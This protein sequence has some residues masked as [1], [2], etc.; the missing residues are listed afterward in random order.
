MEAGSGQRKRYYG[1]LSRWMP[2]VSGRPAFVGRVLTRAAASLTIRR[3]TGEMHS[4]NTTDRLDALLDRHH[5]PIERLIARYRLPLHVFFLEEM[6]E[7]ARGFQD[8][9]RSVYPESVVAFAVKSNPCRGAV[10]AAQRLGLGADVASEY[11]L[12]AALEEGIDPSAIICNGNAKSAEYLGMALH[13]GATIAL[14]ND[15]EILRLEQR[16]RRENAWARVLVRFRGMP[17]SGLTAVDQTTAADWTKFGFHLDEAERLFSRIRSSDRLRFCGP[18]AHIGT[19]IADPVGYQLLLDHLLRLAGLAVELGLSVECIDVGGGFPVTFLTDEE[20]K[21]LT[22]RLLAR[23]RGDSPISEA[24]TWND[25]PMGYGHL[26]ARDKSAPRWIGKSYWSA[27]PASR[28][29]AHI[30]DHRF[31]DGATVIDRLAALGRPRLIV[32]PG[33]SLMAS[34]GVTLVQA[35]GVKKVLGHPVVS[36]DMG[37]NNHGTNL[38]SPDIFPAAVLPKRPDDRPVDAFLAGRLCFSGDMISKA[39][40]QLNRLPASGERCIV[41]HTGAYS[42]DHFASNS[43]GFPLPVKVA[44]RPDGTAELWRAPQTF[45]D[46]FGASGDD[47]T[48]ADR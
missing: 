40:I 26:T 33:R 34:A 28:M 24:V 14:D 3:A 27:F 31:E 15:A 29:L 35:T 37:I 4:V 18:S 17:L 45:T 8:V 20:W 41:Y 46:V 43:C 11:E 38:I 39:K 16:A 48:I 30:L 47:L 22:A 6:E 7:N 23:L 2:R 19:Q 13:A 32:E 5:E 12:Q 10:R 9:L 42:A 21:R 1:Q 25:L 36:L 44:I